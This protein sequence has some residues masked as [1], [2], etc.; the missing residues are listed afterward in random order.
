MFYTLSQFLVN[1]LWLQKYIRLDG[2]VAQLAK[3]NTAVRNGALL[4]K[5]KSQWPQKKGIKRLPNKILN[6]MCEGF[7][8]KRCI[9]N[10]PND[11]FNRRRSQ[12]TINQIHSFSGLSAKHAVVCINRIPCSLLTKKPLPMAAAFNP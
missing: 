5:R 6:S 3:D 1:Y 12:L 7:I 9:R 10:T 11:P 8:E 2:I 4:T